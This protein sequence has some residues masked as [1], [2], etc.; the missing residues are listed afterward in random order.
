MK[1]MRWLFVFPWDVFI[2]NQLG[3]S[4]LGDNACIW[5]TFRTMPHENN[6]AAFAYFFLQQYQERG[7]F[8]LLGLH[9]LVSYISLISFSW[10]PRVFL[11]HAY[12]FRETA[13]KLEQHLHATG[14]DFRST[15][16]KVI[17]EIQNN[18]LDLHYILAQKV[19]SC[20]LP[21]LLSL[22]RAARHT[23]I[24]IAWKSSYSWYIQS[25]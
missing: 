16:V 10:F 2:T 9:K 7:I 5:S 20:K 19:C 23:T 12:F 4:A 3:Y 25:S 21:C 8:I 18:E 11:A 14:D 22:C 24:N 13:G 6:S 1:W 17:E 15:A